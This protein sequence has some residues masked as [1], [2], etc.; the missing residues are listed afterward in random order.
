M[1]F[2]LI[3]CSHSLTSIIQEKCLTNIQVIAIQEEGDQTSGS[4]KINVTVLFWRR[5]LFGKI[6]HTKQIR[7]AF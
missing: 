5:T 6:Y 1:A 2:V 7:S 4:K 3:F